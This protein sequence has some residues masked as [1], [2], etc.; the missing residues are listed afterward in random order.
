MNVL[1]IPGYRYPAD[2][3]EPI[4]CGDLRYSFNLARALARKGLKVTVISRG[5]HG[6]KAHATSNSVRILRYQSG[7]RRIFGTSFDISWGRYKLYR[8]LAPK[9]DLVICNSP[10]SLELPVRRCGP[11]IYICSGLEDVRNYALSLSDMFAYCGIKMLRDPCKRLSWRKATVVN[12][13]ASL[14]DHTLRRW[15][16]PAAKIATIGPGV[17]LER[18]FPQCEKELDA[19]KQGLGVPR[20]R[21]CNK[22]ILCVGR[23]TPAKGIVETVKAF[24]LL[25]RERD[26][27][28]LLIVGVQHSHSSSYYGKILRE[29]ALSGLTDRI[30][31]RENVPE[32]DLPRYYSLARLCSVFSVGYDP[33]PTVIIESLSCGTP[34]VATYFDTRKQMIADGVNSL[35]VPEGDIQAWSHAVKRLLDDDEFYERL[36]RAGMATVEQKFDMDR[37]AEQYLQ[38]LHE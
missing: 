13:T 37:V 17:E 38:V 19:L 21:W 34:V 32:A 9:A 29:I 12:T 20:H 30:I 10:L 25:A 14:E 15:G 6:E 26:D 18:Y 11:L 2:L 33:L 16:V 5:K 7:L 8:R 3:S 22:F 1:Y 27:I 4:S 36:R 24:R 31:V 35:F 28:H 23:F